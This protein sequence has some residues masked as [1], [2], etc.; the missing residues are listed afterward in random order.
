M[1]PQ[2]A[3][4]V[5]ASAVVRAAFSSPVHQLACHD[6]LEVLRRLHPEPTAEPVPT[7]VL[8]ELVNGTVHRYED[9]F[10]HHIAGWN[11]FNV[12]RHDADHPDGSV[13]LG[14]YA[15]AEVVRFYPNGRDLQLT[16]HHPPATPDP[17]GP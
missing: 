3:I 5:L 9:A 13:W 8:I 17:T 12:Q 10:V 2:E 14:T 11:A 15:L 6:A 16:V 1:T 7:G 4:D